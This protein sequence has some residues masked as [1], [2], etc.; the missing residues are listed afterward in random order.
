MQLGRGA[1]LT[2][3]DIKSVHKLFPVHPVDRQRLGIKW[4]DQVYFDVMLPFG[5]R[6]APKIF[7]AVVDALE[8]CIASQGFN[9][10]AHYLDDSVVMG[11]PDL[12]VCAKSLST[13]K[14]VSSDLDV[15]LAP[16]KQESPSTKLTFLVITINS[17]SEKLARLV[18]TLDHWIQC[19]TRTHR[20]LDSL[21]G[22]LQ[23]VCMV[24]QPGRT[25]MCNAIPLLNV[26]NN[27]ITTFA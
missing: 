20:E 25:F 7:T 15:P 8:W 5:L 2:K 6:S 9:H 23:H 3:I 18:E 27:H 4:R 12:E 17:T 24:I 22:I 10:I 14:A 19:K 13:L 11:L 26:P 21:I 1:L 16:E